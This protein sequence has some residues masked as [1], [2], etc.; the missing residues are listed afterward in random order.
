MVGRFYHDFK[1]VGA[2]ESANSHST[3][4]TPPPLQMLSLEMLKR[5]FKLPGPIVLMILLSV[6]ANPDDSLNR[7]R[8]HTSAMF[9]IG[10]V[11]DSLDHGTEQAMLSG[12]QTVKMI[13]SKDDNRG[14]PPIKPAVIWIPKEKFITATICELLKAGVV[15][16][17]SP[18]DPLIRQSV[19]MVSKQFHI[20]LI[21]THWDTDRSNSR[22]AINI[23]PSHDA[24]G[25]AIFEYLSSY[26]K[27]NHV[28]LVLADYGKPLVPNMGDNQAHGLARTRAGAGVS[29]WQRI[30]EAAKCARIHLITQQQPQRQR[31]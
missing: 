27:W 23:H 12:L 3:A 15:A 13:Y 4:V 11:L 1:I 9:T 18:P 6:S 22:F 2:L 24:F 20:P 16:F 28:V 21:E 25:E 17:V 19:R 7:T 10:A 31:L 14:Q 8:R 29:K 5:V 26:S 30:S